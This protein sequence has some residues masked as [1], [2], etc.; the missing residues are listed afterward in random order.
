MIR[1]FDC[2]VTPVVEVTVDAL[3]EFHRYG[4][5][6]RC[7]SVHFLNTPL[8]FHN[9]HWILETPFVVGQGMLEVCDLNGTVHE[10]TCTI[11]PDSTKV[12]HRRQW[13]QMLRDLYKWWGPYTGTQLIRNGTVVI[14]QHTSILLLEALCHEFSLWG[15]M[16]NDVIQPWLGQY[17]THIRSKNMMELSG[18]E[19][20]NVQHSAQ[21]QKMLSSRYLSEQVQVRSRL[22]NVFHP[23]G[24]YIQYLIQNLYG[25]ILELEHRLVAMEYS[26]PVRGMLTILCCV[27]QQLKSVSHTGPISS[28]A[29]QPE[30]LLDCPIAVRD[31]I[32]QGELF[33][34]HQ[35]DL[36]ESGRIMQPYS[37]QVYEL[38][39][40][41]RL[42]EL[43]TEGFRVHPTITEMGNESGWGMCV[44]FDLQDDVLELLYNP[45]FES[46]WTRGGSPQYSLIGEQ[47]PDIVVRSSTQWCILDAKY[48][49][50]LNNVLDSFSTAFS[51][52][53]SVKDLKRGGSPTHSLLLMPQPDEETAIWF[54]SDFIHE[55]HFGCLHFNPVV[56]LDIKDL[57]IPWL[58]DMFRRFSRS[59]DD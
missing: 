52:L 46:Y 53:E 30:Q 5:Q 14:G 28:S 39:C 21:F 48:R 42:I 18:Y 57:N 37:Y 41:Y 44:H 58:W 51:Y 49:S 7:Q 43:C 12:S 1:V 25:L 26:H 11:H 4:V 47:R 13:N 20:G 36:G 32:S 55:N 9:G 38:W 16:L 59:D 45:R 35:M 8:E 22:L 56:F 29:I 10:V 31:F 54:A 27:Q 34:K 3:M 19:L 17:H 15:Q 2:E 40:F 50:G 6:G 24:Q 23:V 33:L